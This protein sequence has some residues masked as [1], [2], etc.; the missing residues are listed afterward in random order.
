M[1][2]YTWTFPAF[3]CIID[4]DGLQTVVTT[5]HWILTGTNK[6]NISA[7]LYGSQTVGQP[8][9]EAF[10]PFPDISEEQVIG[11]MESSMDV[12]ALEANIAIQI[13]LIKHPVTEVLPAPWSN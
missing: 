7:T 1:I 4:E 13:D 12:D 2:N 10:T 9:P 11:W 6:D 5:V 3:D 8:N